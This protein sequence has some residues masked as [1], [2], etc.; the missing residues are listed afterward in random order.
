M[1]KHP[2]V[3]DI[4][5]LNSSG[6]DDPKM[7]IIWVDNGMVDVAWIDMFGDYHRVCVPS[8]ALKH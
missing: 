7:T 1:T 2:E 4:V 6:P 8:K 5:Q 3:G